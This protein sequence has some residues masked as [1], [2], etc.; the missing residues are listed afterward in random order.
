MDGLKYLFRGRYTDMLVGLDMVGEG[1]RGNRCG[2]WFSG[3]FN[4]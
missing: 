4:E 3:L 2:D 1:E